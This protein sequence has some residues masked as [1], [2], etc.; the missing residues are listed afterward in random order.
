[1]VQSA[2]LLKGVPILV[3]EDDPGNARLLAVLFAKQGAEVRTAPD[4]EAAVAI[5]K[6]FRPALIALD[7]VLP[8]MSGLLLVRQLK[9]TSATRDIPVIA[10]S[11][12]DGSTAERLALEGGCAAFVPKP[13]DSQTYMAVVMD[14]VKGQFH[15]A[16]G[17]DTGGNVG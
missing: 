3:V 17:L 14:H 16:P 7:L 11:I 2:G 10:M 9:A 6:T 5:L 13:I 4:A 8:K 12:M 1:M 15:A